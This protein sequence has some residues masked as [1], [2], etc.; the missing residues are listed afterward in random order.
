MPLFTR[1]WNKLHAGA[2]A[3]E[4]SRDHLQPS[5]FVHSRSATNPDI[6]S[7]IYDVAIAGSDDSVSGRFPAKRLGIRASI[8]YVLVTRMAGAPNSYHCLVTIANYGLGDRS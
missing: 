5:R 2:I 6:I 4:K 3:N 7:S 1:L 8:A